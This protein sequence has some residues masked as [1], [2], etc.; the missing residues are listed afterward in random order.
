MPRMT[1]YHPPGAL[2]HMISNFSFGMRALELPGARGKYL[3]LAERAAKRTDWTPLAFAL[4]GTHPHW[5][6]I[7]GNTPPSSFYHS[8][9]TGFGLWVNQQQRNLRAESAGRFVGPIFAAR[10]TTFTVVPQDAPRLISYLHNNPVRAGLVGNA[11]L[12][13][14][15]SHRPFI[16]PE[17]R[18]PWLNA[19]Q[20]LSLCGFSDTYQGRLDLHNLVISA[21]SADSSWFPEDADARAARRQL[22][23]DL[24]APAGIANPS[25]S[26]D[27]TELIFPA[28][29]DSV[30]PLQAR[31]KGHVFEL[32]TE[33]AIV[34]HVSTRR[35]RSRSRERKV[36]R[37]RRLAVRTWVD[38]LGRPLKE[39]A[40]ALGISSAAG[41]KYLR[42]SRANPQSAAPAEGVA[43]R[44]WRKDSSDIKE[45][46]ARWRFNK[47]TS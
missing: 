2:V 45:I 43:A 27:P 28:V 17:E 18:P 19:H 39:I 37:A 13:D 9:H 33:I 41:S 25:A 4:M 47:L 3:A 15:T 6:L 36:C 23:R 8:I 34:T 35:Q 7:A 30:L 1:R 38:Y 31:W 5:T 44:C 32:L 29:I 16:H 24:N 14:W 22:R 20:A 40:T 12:S 11:A 21:A 42:S 10:P 26:C 46:G